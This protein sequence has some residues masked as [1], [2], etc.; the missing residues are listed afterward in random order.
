VLA[1]LAAARLH[2]GGK[3]GVVTRDAG[4]FFVVLRLG[5]AHALEFGRR[6]GRGE[7]EKKVK[8]KEIPR[9]QDNP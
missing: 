6:L 3:D 9:E 5:V 4:A 7:Q 8:I 1:T 2:G